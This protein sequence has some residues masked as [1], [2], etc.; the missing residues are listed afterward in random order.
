MAVF[1]FAP[2]MLQRMSL[3]VALSVIRRDAIFLDAIGGIADIKFRFAF[4]TDIAVFPFDRNTS[5]PLRPIARESV[6]TAASKEKLRW[7]IV[8]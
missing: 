5:L 7:R 3:L 1:L 4:D 6:S 2:I 8:V